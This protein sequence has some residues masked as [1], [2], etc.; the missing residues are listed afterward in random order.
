MGTTCAAFSRPLAFQKKKNERYDKKSNDR[1]WWCGLRMQ[2][3][4][5]RCALVNICCWHWHWHWHWL[6][7]IV[8]PYYPP[9]PV[10]VLGVGRCGLG[11]G[12]L[13]V[14]R[15][16]EGQGGETAA[17]AAHG[18]TPPSVMQWMIHVCAEGGAVLLTDFLPRRTHGHGVPTS[19]PTKANGT[20]K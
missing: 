1:H 11:G 12:T 16:Q 10:L 17:A 19:R 13:T 3:L 15:G 2:D 8:V 14:S 5:Q 7:S 18:F 6:G 9:L 20:I 4:P